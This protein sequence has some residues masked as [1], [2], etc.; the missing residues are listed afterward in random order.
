MLDHRAHC[1]LE[2][3]Q[4][5]Q[6]R[7]D[8][9]LDQGQELGGGAFLGAAQGQGLDFSHTTWVQAQRRTS[10]KLPSQSPSL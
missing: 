5:P 10:A 8:M 3:T 1:L 9:G 6:A 2:V 4:P 7:E